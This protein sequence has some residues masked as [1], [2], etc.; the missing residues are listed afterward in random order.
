MIIIISRASIAQAGIIISRASIAQVGIIVD[1]LMGDIKV[2]EIVSVNWAVKYYL[3]DGR[4][5]SSASLLEKEK[6]EGVN[7]FVVWLV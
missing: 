2:T 7:I 6:L 5:P 1:L 4:F 3:G